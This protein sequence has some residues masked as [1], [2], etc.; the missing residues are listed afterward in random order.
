LNRSS[1]PLFA[2]QFL[3]GC[4]EGG[5]VLLFDLN[6]AGGAALAELDQGAQGGSLKVA[7]GGRELWG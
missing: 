3:V 7:L 5:D 6:L 4:L 2:F 1:T